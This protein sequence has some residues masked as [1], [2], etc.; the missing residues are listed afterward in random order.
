V[1]RETLIVWVPWSII[2]IKWNGRNGRNGGFIYTP[3]G[4]SREYGRGVVNR[5][6]RRS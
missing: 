1:Y 2:L 3:R 5:G 6:R 4:R